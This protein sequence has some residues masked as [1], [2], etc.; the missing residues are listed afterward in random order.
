[1]EKV[2]ASELLELSTTTWC[3]NPKDDQKQFLRPFLYCVDRDINIYV[4]LLFDTTQLCI[5]IREVSEDCHIME[6][7]HSL[8]S[9]CGILVGTDLHEKLESPLERSTFSI[10][11]L[12]MFV[13]VVIQP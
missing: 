12:K 3:R 10:V 11:S 13:L 9:F 6:E 1:M 4:Y 5:F 8:E 7:L 2:H